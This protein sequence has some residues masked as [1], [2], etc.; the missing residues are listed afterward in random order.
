M[1]LFGHLGGTPPAPQCG[2]K[3]GKRQQQ[4]RPLG[5]PSEQ[6]ETNTVNTATRNIAIPC[7]AAVR[8]HER[9]RFGSTH[10]SAL[11][12]TNP[13]M[14]NRSHQLIDWS[15]LQRKIVEVTRRNGSSHKNYR[16]NY[17]METG[18]P[19][20]NARTNKYRYARQSL[21]RAYH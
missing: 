9:G 10:A 13:T 21:T 6:T 2:C 5:S 4:H 8:L 15:Y 12:M 11:M 7:H 16:K 19:S 3:K 14:N 20:I 18:Q 17:R 1:D